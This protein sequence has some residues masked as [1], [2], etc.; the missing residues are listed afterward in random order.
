MVKQKEAFK[1]IS[2]LRGNEELISLLKCSKKREIRTYS[3]EKVCLKFSRTE[4]NINTKSV[5]LY[6]FITYGRVICKIQSNAYILFILSIFF[7]EFS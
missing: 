6:I 2:I 4:E 5:F 7:Q 3:Q 1:K